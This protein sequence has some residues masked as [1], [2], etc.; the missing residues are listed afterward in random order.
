M[1]IGLSGLASGFDWRSMLDQLVEVERAPQRRLQIEK[2]DNRERSSIYGSLKTELS[3]LQGKLTTLSDADFFGSRSVTAS[4][5]ETVSAQV[6]ENATV[7]TYSVNVSQMA[8][9]STLTGS[10]NLGSSLN[11]TSDVSGL[12]LSSAAFPSPVTAGTITI[13]G[14]QVTI[15]TTDSLQTVFDNINS[16]TG[17]AV[18]GSYAPGTD[19]I[20]LS[21]S[22]EIVLGSTTDT[23]NF[24]TAARLFNNGTGTVS[25]SSSLG[26][27][28]QTSVLSGGN[29]TTAIND[30][31]SGAGQFTINGVAINFDVSSDSLENV[32]SR[33]N[34]SGAEVFASYDTVNDQITLTN[35]KTGD[36]G[37]AIADVTGNFASAL[38]LGSGT[39]ARGNNLT[40]TVNGGGVQ[41]SFTNT[42]T[43]ES[44]GINGLTFT[45]HQTGTGTVTVGSDRAKIEKGITDFVAQYNKVQSFIDANT[46]ST[47]NAAGKVSAGPMQS[48][49][50]VLDIAA[51]L[52]SLSVGS[53]SALSTTLDRL[54]D[55]GI[56]TNGYD[57]KLAISDT[58]IFSDSLINDLGK[59][60]TLFQDSTDGIAVLMNAFVE[61]QIGDEGVIPSKVDSIA[62][63]DGGIDDQI[64]QLERVVQ[65]NRER[66]MQ[67][68]ISMETAQ[69]QI[70]NQLKFLQ[71]RFGGGTK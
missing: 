68:F 15:S 9:A 64:A 34:S 13:N 8:S 63:Q 65:S 16:A 49:Q 4:A 30:G 48:E 24:F 28:N 3:V 41:T 70:N 61:K 1:D 71:Q 22:S 56:E 62:E 32:I 55:I 17:G 12:T 21:S 18:S 36:L 47:T 69:S 19:L 45:A 66:L 43:G 10:S 2:L 60:T 25:S 27:V 31:G 26:S 33:I 7:G 53:V 23:S 46:A 42:V 11:S 37:V 5:A 51:E 35:N 54:S 38:G 14:A 59:V 6:S 44:S 50:E 57:N 29:F 20:S 40:Y 39:L 67:S 52:R 58:T